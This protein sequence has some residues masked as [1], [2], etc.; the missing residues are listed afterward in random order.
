MKKMISSA[1]VFGV[2]LSILMVRGAVAGETAGQV[3]AKLEKLSPKERKKAIIEGAKKEGAITI[4]TS[5]RQ[6]QSYPFSKAFNKR[7]PFLKVN[8]FRIAASR[9]VA[10]VQA[11]FNAG[12]HEVDVLNNNAAGAYTIKGLGVLDPYH[13]PERKFFPAAYK[14]KEGY[15]T[16]I[17]VIPVV[18]G[19]NPTQVKPEEVPRSYKDL[20][21]PKWKGK[22][23]LDTDDFEWFVALIDH[24]GREKGLQYMKNLAKQRPS[25]RRGRTLQTQLL[26][27]GENPIAIALHAHTVLDM[28]EKGAPIDWTTLDPYFAK[29]NTIMLPKHAPHP[30]AAALFIDWALSKEGQSMITTFGRVVAR[31]GIKQRFPELGKKKYILTDT[32]MVGPVLNRSIKDFQEIFM[33]S[34]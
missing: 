22:M 14:D 26:M 17:Y 33:K 25:M 31:E 21:A 1:L 27:A 11:E 16:P 12:R 6:D 29:P 15:F 34:R 4:Y 30:H 28:K 9:Q 32:A 7:F 8:S 24:F 5:M 13:S 23:L 2:A 18:L 10:K 3:L 20:L 19:Y